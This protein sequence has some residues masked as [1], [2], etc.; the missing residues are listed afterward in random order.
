M[1][2]NPFI[3]SVMGGGE[4]YDGIFP[5][6]EAKCPCPPSPFRHLEETEE[7]DIPLWMTIFTS[8]VL[9]VMFGALVTDR[10]GTDGVLLTSMTAL[11]AAGIISIKEALEGFSNEGVMTVMALFVVAEGITR[12]GA[13]DWYMA[14]LLG[15]PE[16]NAS[17]QFRMMVPSVV[18]SAFTNNTPQVAIMIPILERWCKSISIPVSQLMIPLSYSSVLGGTIA[19]IGTSTNLVVVGLLADRYPDDPDMQIG[20]WSLGLYGVP[21]AIAGVC[22]I[23]VASPWLLPGGSRRRDGNNRGRTVDKE[24][25]VLLG[26][27]LMPWSPA[28]GRS[29]KRSGLRNTGGIY[30]VSVHRASTGNVHRAVG[31]EFVLNVGDVLYFTGLVEGFGDFCEEHGLQV[32]TSDTEEGEIQKSLSA[33]PFSQDATEKPS[34]DEDDFNYQSTNHLDSL[35]K[36]AREAEPLEYSKTARPESEEERSRRIARMVGK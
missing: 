19:T 33:L 34:A 25:D 30:L 11:L 5:R 8:L 31:Q 12:T 27:R 24:E 13:L 28:A 7:E 26:A 16:G 22:Y 21:V 10:F 18:I 4:D 14:K 32:L 15:R 3:E 6:D 20:I 35:L 36:N 29:V 23:I 17:A 2:G 1:Q 9:V